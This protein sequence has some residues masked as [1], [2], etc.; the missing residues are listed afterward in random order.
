M[1]S[2]IESKQKELKRVR[3]ELQD[4]KDGLSKIAGDINT[5][6]EAAKKQEEEDARKKEEEA[7]E[8]K[9]KED[10]KSLEMNKL[11]K[12]LGLISFKA[13]STAERVKQ[14]ETLI[15]NVGDTTVSKLCSLCVP[16]P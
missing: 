6:E 11:T 1:L 4:A 12:E 13:E 10:L 3:A 9:K 2:S 14:L 5:A 15:M 8:E 7:L 16:L